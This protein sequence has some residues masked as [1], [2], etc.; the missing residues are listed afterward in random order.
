MVLSFAMVLVAIWP[1]PSQAHV[2]ANNNALSIN[3]ALPAATSRKNTNGEDAR[4]DAQEQQEQED[5]R[6]DAQDPASGSSSQNTHWIS[7]PATT[8]GP[9]SLQAQA[10]DQAWLPFPLFTKA[11]QHR[12]L[13][14]VAAT[15]TL[16]Y[17]KVLLCQIIAPNAP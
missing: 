1:T 17:F 8:G 11:I 2:P 13:P 6:Q 12:A 5:A 14:Q 10:L 9:N 4:Q 3:Q 16:R 15:T 7:A